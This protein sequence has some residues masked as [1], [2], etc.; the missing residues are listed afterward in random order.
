MFLVF[1]K[2]IPVKGFAAMAVYPFIFV[3]SECKSYQHSERWQ[4]LIRHE[5]IHFEQQKELLLIFFYLWYVIEYFIRLVIHKNSNEAYRN[6]SFEREA[7]KNEGNINY[8][9]T[10]NRFSW[11]KHL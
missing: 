7:Y 4:I 1:N 3:R 2:L 6:I 8:F 11:L 10:R 9:S 5:K